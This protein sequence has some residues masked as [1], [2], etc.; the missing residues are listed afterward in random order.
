MSDMV[1]PEKYIGK[2]LKF[3]DEKEKEIIEVSDDSDDEDEEDT[4]EDEYSEKDDEASEEDVEKLKEKKEDEY[5]PEDLKNA[6]EKCKRLGYNFHEIRAL[7]SSDWDIITV[8]TKEERTK[9]LKMIELNMK[10][11]LDYCEIGEEFYKQT[12]KDILDES[13]ED[14]PEK[15][16]T[17]RWKS[18][19]P[20]LPEDPDEVMDFLM[21]PNA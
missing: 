1:T 11:V 14:E 18:A 3:D 10:P 6:E 21:D 12:A 7:V 2:R 13:F 19:F 17:K 5:D 9:L 4:E 20:K 8:W 16:A 15:L